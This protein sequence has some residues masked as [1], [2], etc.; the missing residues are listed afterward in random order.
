MFKTLIQYKDVVLQVQ[1]IQGNS[2]AEIQWSYD[3]LISTMEFPILV[4]RY[5]YIESGP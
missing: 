1:V 5:F 4:K 2:T 3:C